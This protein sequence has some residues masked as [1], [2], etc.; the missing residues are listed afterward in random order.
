MILDSD[1]LTVRDQ[2]QLPENLAGRS[3][4]S[5]DGSLMYAVSDSGV[6]ALP[7]GALFQSSPR[8]TVSQEDVVLLSSFCDG[9]IATQTFTVTNLGSGAID[10]TISGGAPGITVTPSA[11]KTPATI[12]VTA[13]ASVFQNSSGTVTATLQISSAQAVNLPLSVRVLVNVR[14]A[15]QR[16][17]IVDV[18][19][20]LVDLL[21]DPIRDRFYVLRQ[22][23]NQV[24]VF[25]GSD[26]SQIAVL[27]TGNTPTQMAFTLD[28]HYLVVGNDNSCIANVFDLETLQPARPI[29]FPL[30]HYPRS[31]AFSSNAALAACRRVGTDH[32]IDQVNWSLGS[33]NALPSLGAF[34]NTIN[35]NTVLTPTPNGSAIV[36]AEAD[37]SVLLY[38]A[39]A[40]TFTISRKDFTALGGPYAASG[41]GQFVIGN[42]L[43]NA[44]LVPMMAFDASGGTTSGFAFAGQ[45]GMRSTVPAAGPGL[46]ERMDLSSGTILRP[47]RMVEAPLTGSP[48]AAFVRTLA[49]LANG[50]FIVA[51]TTSGVT[52][53]TSNYDA[54]MPQP[55]IDKV[56]NAADL[57]QPVAPGGLISVFGE[58][59]SPVNAATEDV[60]LPTALAESCMT[61]NGAPVPVLFVSPGQVNAQLPFTAEGSVTLVLRSPGGISDNFP[62]TVQPAAPSVFRS[63]TAGPETGLPTV[64]R[65][66]NNQLVTLSNPVHRGD[67]IVIYA[68]G[69]G[70]T[71]PPVD[72]G[73]AAPADPLAWALIA[74]VVDLGGVPLSVLYAGLTPG[75]VGVYQINVVVPQS[76][77]LGMSVPLIISQ[78]TGSTSLPVR[79]ID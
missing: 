46:V 66:T 28:G 4:L 64:L 7:V 32:T 17:T 58:N 40:G 42:N 53:L 51:L 26:Q 76:A 6:M 45:G 36:A 41:A 65:V 29:R 50:N 67:T 48:D 33:A 63:G 54:S 72:A 74:P 22:D 30:G 75:E 69:L 13:D 31:I 37:G 2:L 9:S 8:L 15:D 68:T 21:A 16:G 34:Q 61:A 11:G 25:D 43:L 77:P 57:T 52:V 18:P 39:S 10:F 71:S 19:G 12:Q 5:S 79:V 23:K 59:M 1:N 24:L 14:D 70:Q 56:V 55:V 49:P 47:T 20:K 60:P 35:Q 38:D 62:I 3:L 44:S 78:G 73:A 27:R